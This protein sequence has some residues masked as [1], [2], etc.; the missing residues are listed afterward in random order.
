[1]GTTASYD[2]GRGGPWT[3][4]KRDASSLARYG[5]GLRVARALAGYVASS[6]GS[7]RT[8]ETANV[9]ARTGSGLG[10][11]LAAASEPG[12]ISEAFRSIGLDHLVGCDRFTVL[13]GL[14]DEFSGNGSDLETQAARNALFD[15]LSVILPEETAGQMDNVT[16][17]SSSVADALRM[18]IAALVY[19]RAIPII[20]ERLTRLQNPHLAQLRDREIRDYIEA[21]VALR[22]SN[23]SPLTIDWSGR[24]GLDLINGI[25][26]ATYD[27]LEDNE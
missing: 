12:G 16:L 21:L 25:L 18:Y 14:L 9:G 2:G 11:F 15:V 10:G 5:G 23:I 6:G 24:A 13:S 19:N 3:K 20:D 26:R 1:M 8:T 17:D 27:Q 4:L 7:A 22:T